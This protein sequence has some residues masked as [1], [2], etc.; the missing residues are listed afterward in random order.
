[1]VV[2]SIPINNYFI[3]KCNTPINQKTQDDWIE[4]DPSICSLKETHYIPTDT[5]RL[6]NE[7]MEKD[8]S[9]MWKQNKNPKT[10][11]QDM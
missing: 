11:K 7:R 6:L 2:K 1:M 4:Q 8:I 3:C 10:G 9:C 5:Q